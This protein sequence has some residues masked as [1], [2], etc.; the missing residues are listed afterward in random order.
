MSAIIDDEYNAFLEE[1]KCWSCTK[2]GSRWKVK[3]SNEDRFSVFTN[4]EISFYFAFDGHGGNLVSQYCKDNFILFVFSRFKPHLEKYKV[5]K[6]PIITILE[7]I[8]TILK[9]TI[10]DFDKELYEFLKGE[11]EK[12]KN[13]EI[14]EERRLKVLHERIWEIFNNMD[15]EESGL[16]RGLLSAGGEETYAFRKDFK[17]KHFSELTDDDFRELRYNISPTPSRSNSYISY[18]F[19]EFNTVGTTLS[20]IIIFEDLK[21]AD[22]EAKPYGFSINIGDSQTTVQIQKVDGTSINVPLSHPHSPDDTFENARIVKAGGKVSRGKIRDKNYGY[23]AVARALGDFYLKQIP[24]MDGSEVY[25]FSPNTIVT[26]DPDIKVFEI[27]PTDSLTFTICSDGISDHFTMPEIH[28]I[29]SNTI[30]EG[31]DPAKELCESSFIKTRD[32]VTAIV[33]KRGPK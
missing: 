26:A 24:M 19:D 30:D 11:R 2:E 27:N 23:L 4:D 5:E 20:G 7:E 21:D 9:Q 31:K 29:V 15:P 1:Q 3:G 25:D 33:I 16:A 12:K 17:E 6:T 10:F 32:D 14:E 8:R 28:T 13:E 18:E 22:A